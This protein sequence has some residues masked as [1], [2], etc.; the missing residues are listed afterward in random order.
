MFALPARMK[1][2]LSPEPALQREKHSRGRPVV[3]W[4]CII[5]SRVCSGQD[6]GSCKRQ[7]SRFHF[8]LI[9]LCIEVQSKSDASKIPTIL[10]EAQ[11][12]THLASVLI[13]G[14]EPAQ[15]SPNAGGSLPQFG[16]GWQR[17]PWYMATGCPRARVPVRLFLAG[18]YRTGGR[19]AGF[20]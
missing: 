3:G 1:S 13:L 8:R 6:R 16:L 20:T 11:E 10:E 17:W 15:R 12:D 5:S 7:N 9:R 19:S 14:Y 2:T 18:W 4:E